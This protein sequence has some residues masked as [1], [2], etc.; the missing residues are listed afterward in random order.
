MA[1][2]PA[3]NVSPFIRSLLSHSSHLIVLVT[4][5][6][7]LPGVSLSGRCGL[8]NYLHCHVTRHRTPVFLLWSYVDLHCTCRCILSMS[9]PGVCVPFTVLRYLNVIIASCIISEMV[10][11]PSVLCW[12][13][14][15][16]LAHFCVIYSFLRMPYSA[17]SRRFFITARVGDDFTYFLIALTTFFLHFIGSYMCCFRSCWCCRLLPVESRIDFT[18]RVGI[19]SSL[20]IVVCYLFL[21]FSCSSTLSF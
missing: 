9:W 2:S 12:F 16:C 4:L 7:V 3:F 14:L 11:L 10:V 15:W 5:P 6:L 19:R 1:S 8:W 20:I 18:V 21:V 17:I 13:L